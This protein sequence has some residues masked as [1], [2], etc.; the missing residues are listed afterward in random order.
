MDGEDPPEPPAEPIESELELEPLPLPLFEPHEE[1][2]PDLL[3]EYCRFN[4]TTIK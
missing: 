3:L 2:S 4:E 1:E